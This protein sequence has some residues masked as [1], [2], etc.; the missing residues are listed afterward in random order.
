M[1]SALP[2]ISY[3]HPMFLAPKRVSNQIYLIL[4]LIISGNQLLTVCLFLTF[5]NMFIW[6]A[7]SFVLAMCAVCAMDTC[8]PAIL[9]D[10]RSRFVPCLPRLRLA[11]FRSVWSDITLCTSHNRPVQLNAA[12]DAVVQPGQVCRAGEQVPSRRSTR[13]PMQRPRLCFLSLS[14]IFGCSADGR[15]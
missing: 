5:F 15:E 6:S 9:S 11:S 8:A 2:L 3:L 14:S 7:V 12:V 1:P 4:L 13:S 10:P